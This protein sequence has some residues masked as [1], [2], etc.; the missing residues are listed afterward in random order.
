MIR[1]Q[2]AIAILTLVLFTNCQSENREN[3][4][5]MPKS[6]PTA[7][8]AGQ[9]STQARNTTPAR[10]VQAEGKDVQFTTSDGIVIHGSLYAAGQKS[11]TVLC[12]HQWRSDRSSFNALAA[13]L[14]RAGF[15]VLSIDMRG[16]GGST[17]TSSGK[18]VRPDRKAEKDVAAAMDF[19]RTQPSVDAARIG[20]IGASYGSSNAV[21]YA[22]GDRNVRALVLLSPG[23]N[24]FNVLPTRDAVGRLG[25]R[26][27]FAVASSE[28]LRSVETVDAYKEI[29]PGI[30]TKIYEDAGHGTDILDAGVGLDAEILSFLKKN[31]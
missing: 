5:D 17:K 4:Q 29:V 6:E 11:P 14:Q 23:L 8:A 18:S 24:Y 25:G 3:G 19:L 22:A 13:Q 16:Y 15:T 28:D 26:P 21:I 20:I 2:L 1:R 7:L 9:A 27:L 10:A 30:A 12:L 31:L